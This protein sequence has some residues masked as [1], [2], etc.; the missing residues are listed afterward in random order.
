MMFTVHLRERGTALDSLPQFPQRSGMAAEC[1]R[2]QAEYHETVKAYEEGV[3]ALEKLIGVDPQ[4]FDAAIQ[5]LKGCRAASVLA[6]QMRDAHSNE[7]HDTA[8]GA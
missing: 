5:R 7:A 4:V 8:G 6:Q 2:L 3:T 1:N